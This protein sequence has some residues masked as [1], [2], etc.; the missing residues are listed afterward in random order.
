MA[1]NIDAHVNV[2]TR[3]RG[4]SVFRTSWHLLSVSSEN[5]CSRASKSSRK[6]HS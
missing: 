5:W 6:R 2:S 1:L 3:V 4:T